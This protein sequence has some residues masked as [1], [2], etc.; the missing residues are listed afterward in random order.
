MVENASDLFHWIET[1]ELSE[2]WGTETCCLLQ[3][4]REEDGSSFWAVLRV[5]HAQVR[6]A[7][8]H[9]STWKAFRGGLWGEASEI[10]N[11]DIFLMKFQ[12]SKL[13]GQEIRSLATLPS[14]FYMV[15]SQDFLCSF[16]RDILGLVCPCHCCG[17]DQMSICFTFCPQFFYSTATLPSWVTLRKSVNISWVLVFSSVKGCQ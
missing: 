13:T 10:L 11:L 2:S 6:L 14:W 1:H 3:E 17:F 5:P 16:F 12:V 9:I 7:K 4:E 15:T 8:G